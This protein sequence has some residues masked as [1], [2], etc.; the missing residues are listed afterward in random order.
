MF[1]GSKSPFVLLSDEWYILANKAFPL[2]KHYGNYDLIENGV[3]Q[4]RDFLDRFNLEKK[5]FPKLLKTKKTISIITSDLAYNI[6]INE[7]KPILEK[8]KNLTVNFFKIKNN[9]FG[10]SV[11]VAGLLT[12]KDIIEQLKDKELGS[13]V[14]TTYRILNDEQ[15]LTLDDMTLGDISTQLGVD[16]KISNDSIYQII[17]EISNEK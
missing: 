2:K 14:W 13:S 15:T 3:G 10:D 4:F 9:F 5:Q 12:G 6:F 7:I 1:P 17:K 16:F 11:T 8:I